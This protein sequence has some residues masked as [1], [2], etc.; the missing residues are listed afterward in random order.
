MCLKRTL[1]RR[2][3][4]PNTQIRSQSHAQSASECLENCL[5]LV[6]CIVPVQIVNVQAYLGVIDETLEKFMDE[7][8]VEIPN[9][10]TNIFHPILQTRATGKIHHHSRQGLIQRNIGMTIA[11]DAP[12]VANRF[13]DRL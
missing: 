12:L 13:C 4:S 2:N 6:M 3:L 11:H 9:Q 10:G 5:T 1:G 7:V 8:D